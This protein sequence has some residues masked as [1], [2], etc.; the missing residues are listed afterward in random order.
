MIR[1]PGGARG[2]E[3]STSTLA[4]GRY[5]RHRVYKIG[6]EEDPSDLLTKALNR[7]EQMTHA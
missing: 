3:E 6:V 2:E 5:G 1:N 4:R 7:D